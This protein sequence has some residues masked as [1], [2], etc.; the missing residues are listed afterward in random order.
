[1]SSPAENRGRPKKIRV[2]KTQSIPIGT[3]QEMARSRGKC[4]GCESP[5]PRKVTSPVVRAS[6]I[7][8]SL[9]PSSEH[10]SNPKPTSDRMF[11]LSRYVFLKL[12]SVQK[13]NTNSGH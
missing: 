1:M 4:D 8:G 13:Q 5:V 6:V 3:A 9:M 2:E 12:Q 10:L 11:Q 7:Q